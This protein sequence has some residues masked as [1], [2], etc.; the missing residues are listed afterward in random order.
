[1]NFDFFS[2]QEE[3]GTLLG[4]VIIR[5]GVMVVHVSEGD[6]APYSITGQAHEHWFEGHNDNPDRQWETTAVWSCLNGTY[7]GVWVENG[8]RY[9]FSFQL[10]QA[11]TIEQ[12][13]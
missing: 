1:V 9:L 4:Y 6:D 12:D 8:Y 11:T 5:G 10:G 13:S 7:V 2:F 3:P